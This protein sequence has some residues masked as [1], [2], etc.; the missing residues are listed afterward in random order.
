[1]S[2][3]PPAF[4]FPEAPGVEPPEEYARLPGLAG[5]VPVTLPGGHRAG[6]ASRHED[7]RT[8]LADARF[9]RAAYTA[10]TMV[11]RDRNSLPLMLSDAPEHTRRRRCVAA[12]FS[13]HRANRA[14]AGMEALA[15]ALIAELR[16][17]GPPADLVDAFAVP[18]PLAVICDL[19][20]VPAADRSRFRP[21]VN[22]MM[23]TSGYPRDEV[24]AAQRELHAYF[25]N[26][27]EVTWRD[28]AAGRPRDGLLA[29]LGR[30]APPDRRVSRA[31][32]VALGA[33]LLIAG[34]ETT[35]NQL[36]ICLYLLLNDSRRWVHLR[37]N[38]DA[39]P[40]AIEEMLRWTPFNATGGVP[41]VAIEDVPLAC[42]VVRAGEV[43][44]P[45]I[46]AAN[47]DP[48]VFE[49]PASLRLGRA[50]NPHLAFGHGRHHC[51]GAHLARVELQVAIGALLRDLPDLALAAPESELPW[52]RGMAV[53]G[54]WHLP[55]RWTGAPGGPRATR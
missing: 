10:E 39:V 30:P 38:P 36:A 40:G 15:G 44:V 24:A 11:A 42:G 4:P 49:E 45:V 16:S 54:V 41:H 53:R 32:A 1:V 27:I 22:A 43:V 48:E 29:K 52:R 13:A 7:V 47:R 20:G 26:L 55:V 17:A 9:S 21:W 46:D 6:L 2:G 12:A 34:Y 23:S 50:A 28:C 3:A 8:V 35:S 37:E 31:E 19:L 25:A 14:R 5:L 18:F 33:G 51:L